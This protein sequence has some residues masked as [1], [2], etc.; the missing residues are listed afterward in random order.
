MADERSLFSILEE[1]TGAGAAPAKKVEGDAVGGNEMPSLVAKD[2]AGNLQHVPLR[3]AG[4]AVPTLNVPAMVSKDSSGFLTYVDS[5]DEGEAA[6][7]DNLTVLPA[8]DASNNM[9]FLRVDAFGNLQV[10]SDAGTPR[11]INGT[12]IGILST[13]VVVATLTLAVSKSFDDIDVSASA[14]HPTYWKLEQVNDMTTT[15]IADGL[16]G[17]GQYTIKFVPAN[18]RKTSGASGTQSLKLSGKQLIGN[19]TDL[20][21]TITAIEK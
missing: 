13:F 18:L 16:S 12:T 19:V 17:P 2:L 1:S 4:A 5:R 7:D 14:N 3:A 15:L 10:N 21:G 8:K 9:Q 6:P 11:D 20:H